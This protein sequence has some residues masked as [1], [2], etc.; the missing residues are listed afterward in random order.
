MKKTEIDNAQVASL[1][2]EA[3]IESPKKSKRVRL[4]TL[5]KMFGHKTRQQH[6]LEEM[7]KG[8]DST[9][10]CTTQRQG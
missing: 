2:R 3:I 8:V 4:K 5:L 7:D 1:I 10:K 9:H 6:W